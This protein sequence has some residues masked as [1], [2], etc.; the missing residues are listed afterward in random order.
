MARPVERR[1]I[2]LVFQADGRLINPPLLHLR[3]SAERG[4]FRQKRLGG[5]LLQI[6]RGAA[7]VTPKV[8]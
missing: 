4:N 1:I 8:H 3:C 6:V 2:G 7:L 5:T